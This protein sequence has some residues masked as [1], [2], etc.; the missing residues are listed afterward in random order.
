MEEQEHFMHCLTDARGEYVVPA[1]C[2]LLQNNINLVHQ[3]PL[4]PGSDFM[5]Q[6]TE[7]SLPAF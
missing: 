1:M 4:S 6:E 2:I 5:C 3:D 7:I